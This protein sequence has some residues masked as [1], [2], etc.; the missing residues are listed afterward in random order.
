MIFRRFI[1]TTL[2][3]VM[4]KWWLGLIKLFSLTTGIISF[5]LIWLFYVDHQT[6]SSGE[7]FIRNCSLENILLFASVLIITTVLYFMILKSQMT[8]RHKEFFIRR[9]YGE[10]SVGIAGILV[11]E[12][13]AY[14]VTALVL[15]LVLIDQ[16]APIF[17]II[18]QRS[19]DILAIKSYSGSVA[20]VAFLIIL[21][22]TTT[23]IPAF[24]C[25]QK[26]AVEFLRKIST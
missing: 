14:V 3:L 9:L 19:I 6:S 5:L 26:T 23:F 22:I 4:E 24:I 20:I 12:T 25:S 17:N 13:F 10:T 2:R 11:F 16:I 18:T 15:S 21:I 1:L 8:F 7:P